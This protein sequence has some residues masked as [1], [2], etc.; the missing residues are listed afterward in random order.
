MRRTDFA[1]GRITLKKLLLF[2]FVII[3]LAG[4]FLATK[5]YNP[6][7]GEKDEANY[8]TY[9]VRRSDINPSV[10]AIGI[11]K[12]MVGAEVRV[13]SRISGI[14]SEL[15]ANVGD[16]VTQGDL[17]AE[18]DPTELHA[19]CDLA[20]A[21]LENARANFK[22]AQ[23]DLER[24]RQLLAKELISKEQFEMAKTSFEVR[25]SEIEREE[26][27]L[28]LAKIQLGY[29][30]ITAPISGV[31]SSV[32]TQKGETVAASFSAPTFVNIIDLDRLEV[33]TYV[34]ETDI[35]R[36]HDGQKAVFTVDT[37]PGMQFQGRVTAI[38]PK[39]VIQENVVNY[40]AT[41][42][43]TDKPE[44]EVLR[45]EMTT[46]V[47]IFLERRE[48]VLTIPQSAIQYEDGKKVVQKLENNVIIR[49]PVTTG[50]SRDGQVEIIE[51]LDENDSIV[52]TR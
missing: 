29:T 11:I 12:P 40:I 24:Q 52:I 37:Y 19:K 44:N 2:A 23:A 5:T 8:Q 9:T 25:K 3:V 43:I 10:L 48:N 6:F 4:I 47:T 34:D 30:K 14:V 46:S 51:G 15:H 45:P 50:M 31:I 39:A 22:Y 33:W 32:S 18:L 36:I 28:S 13:G 1:S 16:R 38:Y 49:Q 20:N 42:Q 21:A 41:L 27:N 26:A 7:G 17:L 35:G